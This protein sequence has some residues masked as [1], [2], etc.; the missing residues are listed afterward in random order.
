MNIL[1]EI[2]KHKK[3]EVTENKSLY[4]EKLLKKS[5]YFDTP[6]VSLKKYLLREDK[7]GII[8]EIKRKSPS[9]GDI[10]PYISVEQISIGY[11]QAGASALSV[12]TDTKYFGGKNEDLTVARKFNY[13]PILRKEFIIDEYQITEAKSI[14]ADAILLIAA[15]LSPAKSKSLAKYAKTLGL[16]VILEIT[17]REDTAFFNEHIDVVGVNNRDLETF[18]VDIDRSIKA[19][20]F[21]PK[22]FLKISESG[23]S[24]AN[25]IR[26]LKKLGY[27]GFL[28]GETFMKTSRP[29]KTCE[30]L[31]RSLKRN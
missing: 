6:T 13:C 10:N 20:K 7:A 3:K 11:M 16:E 8:A 14:G 24:S 22:S 4:P 28:I 31:I 2:I 27:N 25:T 26:Q 15:A 1:K 17:K 18:E 12:L 29:A 30:K 19:A 23:I 21:I 9:K 5:I